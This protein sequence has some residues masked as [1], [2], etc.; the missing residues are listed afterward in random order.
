ME[1]YEQ[2]LLPA[3]G[4]VSDGQEG[5]QREYNNFGT[6]AHFEFFKRAKQRQGITLGLSSRSLIKR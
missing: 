2:G 4:L 6:N 5:D 1:N 3:H